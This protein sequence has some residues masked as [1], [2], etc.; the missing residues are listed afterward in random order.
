MRKKISGLN[1]SADE[2]M[3]RNTLKLLRPTRATRALLQYM[4]VKSSILLIFL[5]IIYMFPAY[6]NPLNGYCI[7]KQGEKVKPKVSA[8][9]EPPHVT[10]SVKGKL[11]QLVASKGD[12]L[13]ILDNKGTYVTSTKIIQYEYSG[14][15]QLILGKDGWLWIDGE[16]IDYIAHLNFNQIPPSIDTPIPVSELMQNPCSRWT[17][18]EGK[19]WSAQSI[20]SPTLDRIFVTGYPMTFF[21]TS[22]SVTLEVVNGK[23]KRLPVPAHS[24]NFYADI[25]NLHG[26]LLVGSSGEPFFYDGVTVISLLK[27]FAAR[28]GRNSVAYCAA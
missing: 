27:N 7:S 10:F 11:F 5:L 6:A 13:N 22:Q 14:I 1:Q 28:I 3:R 12:R 4:K 19:C 24:A 16:E 15:K 2:F 21:G 18:F 8:S 25:P 26:V 17:L 9:Q 23:T 20:Y